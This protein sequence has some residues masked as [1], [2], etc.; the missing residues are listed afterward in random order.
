MGV[1]GLVLL[2][3]FGS[4]SLTVGETGVEALCLELS[5]VEDFLPRSVKLSSILVKEEVSNTNTS[6]FVLV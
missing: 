3:D 6:R 4:F 5:G 1:L 2:R